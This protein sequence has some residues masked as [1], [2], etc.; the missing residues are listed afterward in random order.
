M[1][2]GRGPSAGSKSSKKG[3]SGLGIWEERPDK[4]IPCEWAEPMNFD[5]EVQIAFYAIDVVSVWYP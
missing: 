2:L 3:R 1:L 5:T 4:M